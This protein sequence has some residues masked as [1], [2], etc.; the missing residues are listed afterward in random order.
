MSS[1]LCDRLFQKGGGI[2]AETSVSSSNNISCSLV[3]KYM[4]HELVRLS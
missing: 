3:M 4:L 1:M 2:F